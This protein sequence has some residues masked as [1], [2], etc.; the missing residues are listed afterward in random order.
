MNKIYL[1]LLVDLA[2]GF[3]LTEWLQ[4][5]FSES[6]GVKLVLASQYFKSSAHYIF[7]KAT[8]EAFTQV[9]ADKLKEQALVL[10]CQ[11]LTE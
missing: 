9:E 11:R 3:I 5:K 7:K 2:P 1:Y 4:A 6:I 10:N 8:G